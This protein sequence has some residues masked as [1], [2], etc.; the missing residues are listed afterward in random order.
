MFIGD[1]NVVSGR[2]DSMTTMTVPPAYG[3]Q[4]VPANLPAPGLR[5]LTVGLMLSETVRIYRAGFAQFLALGAMVAAVTAGLQGLGFWLFAE[6]FLIGFTTLQF[7][8]VVAGPMLAVAVIVLVSYLVQVQVGAAIVGVANAVGERRTCSFTAAFAAT[9]AVVPRVLVPV[10]LVA[11]GTWLGLAVVTSL[12]AWAIGT[13]RDSGQDAAVTTVGM[14]LLLL[15]VG[16]I[17]TIV[18]TV[19]AA[20]RFYLFVPVVASERCSGFAALGRSWRLTTGVSWRIFLGLFL[21]G[22]VNWF[23][24]QIGSMFVSA[25]TPADLANL[26]GIQDMLWKLVPAVTASVV[27]TGVATTFVFPILTIMSNVV[28]RHRTQPPAPVAPMTWGGFPGGH[29]GP[30]VPPGYPGYPQ[31]GYPERPWPTDY[32]GNVP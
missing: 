21:V 28:Y 26:G 24:G 6:R 8:G 12:M 13:V 10:L 25:V 27:V 18:L 17:L 32:P 4:Y 2:V 29:P 5:E 23:A 14:A 15:V 9:R 1:S 7:A 11:V 22:L 16:S 3:S 31:P 19:V 20:V 30:A